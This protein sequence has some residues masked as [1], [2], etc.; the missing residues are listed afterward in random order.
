MRYFLAVVFFTDGLAYGY[1]FV[2]LT[3]IVFTCLSDGKFKIDLSSKKSSIKLIIQDELTKLAEEAED[4]EE[5]DAENE[6]EEKVKE[7][8]GGSG[9]GVEVKA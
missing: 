5:E 6:E 9:S 2:W 7:K 4:G 3:C 1:F 8:A